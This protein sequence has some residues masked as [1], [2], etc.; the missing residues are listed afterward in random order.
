MN[1]KQH[2]ALGMA[3]LGSAALIGTSTQPNNVVASKRRGKKVTKVS[4]TYRTKATK[5]SHKSYYS[6]SKTG[7]TY[8][9]S[10]SLKKP[11]LKANHTLKQY[12]KTTWTRSKQ[13]VVTKKGKKVRYYYVT[14]AK[15]HATGWVKA[16]ALKAGKN[17]QATTP[18][19]VATK[20]YYKNAKAGKIYQLKG[21]NRYVSLNCK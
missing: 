12:V 5:V 20:A 6:L 2:V 9:L 10:G 15:D 8:K 21:K 1:L 17:G 18:K 3:L 16:S 11:V 13:M 19:K 7:K 4:K 14:N